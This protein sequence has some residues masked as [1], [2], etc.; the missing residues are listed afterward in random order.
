MR[1][2]EADEKKRETDGDWCKPERNDGQF[3]DALSI[4]IV[5]YCIDFV[6]YFIEKDHI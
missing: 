3:H 2:G 5:P 1:A 6:F 4:F